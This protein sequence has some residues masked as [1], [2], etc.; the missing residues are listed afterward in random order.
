MHFNFPASVTEL[1]DI[2]SN[3]PKGGCKKLILEN[4]ENHF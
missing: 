4:L 1:W 2:F 3:V